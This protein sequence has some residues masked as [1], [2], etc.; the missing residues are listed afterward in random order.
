MFSAFNVPCLFLLF[1][2]GTSIFS[3]ISNGQNGLPLEI[4]FLDQIYWL[5]QNVQRQLMILIQL[6]KQFLIL[7]NFGINTSFS[8]HY[9]GM[10]KLHYIHRDAKS[11]RDLDYI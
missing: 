2:G 8:P 5:A 9:V 1:Y 10:I 7:T 6:G 3:K 11:I 4:S